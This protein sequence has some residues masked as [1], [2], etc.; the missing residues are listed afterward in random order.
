MNP[1]FSGTF[2]F[3]HVTFATPGG[4]VAFSAADMQMMVTYAQHA[5]VPIN[6][7]VSQEYGPASAAISPTPIEYTATLSSSTFSDSDLQGWVND[8]LSKNGLSAADSCIVVPCPTGIG[9]GIVGAN[10]GYH[11]VA[12]GPYAVFGVF[13]TGL[14]LA[15]QVDQYAMVVSHEM[16]EVVVDPQANFSNPEVGDPCCENCLTDFYRAYFDSFNNYLG[17]NRLT[18]SSQHFSTRKSVRVARGK[19]QAICGEE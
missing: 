10:S 1:L 4:N 12:N 19:A 18:P 15:D 16:A 5:I 17:T 9:A 13:T 7:F 11:S 6:E 14:T 8:I 3:V 2:Y